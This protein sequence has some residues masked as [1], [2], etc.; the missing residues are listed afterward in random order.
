MLTLMQILTEPCCSEGSVTCSCGDGRLTCRKCDG[1]GDITCPYCKGVNDRCK[2]G[3]RAGKVSCRPCSGSGVKTCL[4]CGGD[5]R[6][7]CSRWPACSAQRQRP[8]W[9][10]ARRESFVEG[11]LLPEELPKVFGQRRLLVVGGCQRGVAL[12]AEKLRARGTVLSEE[13]REIE[14]RTQRPRKPGDASREVWDL[15]LTQLPADTDAEDL[16]AICS[17]AAPVG[18][19]VPHVRMARTHAALPDE[20]LV[21]SVTVLESIFHRRVSDRTDYI[22]LEPMRD[23]DQGRVEAVIELPSAEEMFRL[24]QDYPDRVIDVDILGGVRLHVLPQ[25]CQHI[26]IPSELYEQACQIICICIC[27]YAHTCITYI[28]IYIYTYMHI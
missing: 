7:A 16:R 13:V 28:Y 27:T 5:G 12:A 26:S 2:L 15:D 20:R 17:R 10:V 1:A 18:A 19:D 6:L 8:E 4:R 14:P 9:T 11:H 22:Q 23:D 3:C 21:E 25:P 24:L